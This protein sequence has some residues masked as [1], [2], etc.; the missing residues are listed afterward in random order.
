[1]DKAEAILERMI[2]LHPK[3]ID[4]GLERV[5]ALLN[6]LGDPH[7]ALPPTIHVAGTN[8]KGST[9]AF[10]RSMAEAAGKVVHVYASPHLVHFHE[11]IRLAGRYVSD[12]ALI[13]AL[14]ECERVNDGNP[15]TFFEITTV[16]AFLLFSQHPADLL[17]LEV[18]L[19][20]RLDATNVIKKPAATVVTPIAHD[21]E[22][23]LGSEITGIAREKAGIFKSSAPAILA[24]QSDDVREALEQKARSVGTGPLS[25]GGQDWLSYEEHGRLIF[26]DEF[27]LMDL[28]LPRLGGRHQLINAG[29]AI[30]SLRVVF[31]DL[32]DRAIE[33]GMGDVNWP[34]RM[35]R[36]NEGKLH[37]LLPKDAELWLDGGHNPQAGHALASALADLEE[38]APR[39]LHMI[40]GMLN[41]K[42]P[43]GYFAP[44]KG[45]AKDIITVP[46]PG[47]IAAIDPVALAQVAQESGIPA[48]AAAS[49]DEALKRLGLQNLKPAP[50]ILIAGSLYLAGAVLSAN[51][52]PPT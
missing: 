2:A 28:P 13:D 16:A 19:G 20:G 10:M 36:L 15:I 30:A 1:M 24:P 5:T 52:T 21:H 23:F 46:I 9:S 49:L 35:Q 34:A 44:F 51:G 33:Q 41:T 7:L 48:S 26:Q 8:G 29:T 31:P 17:I 45:L 22:G 37:A 43:Q 6:K 39:P 32:P 4:L 14:L 38:K 42:D 11:R 12:E 3:S 47:S 27:G 40:V 25:I 18:G 50:R